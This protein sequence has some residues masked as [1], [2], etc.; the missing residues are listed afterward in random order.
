MIDLLHSFPLHF[1]ILNHMY[2]FY[3]IDAN[4]SQV[5]LILFYFCFLFLLEIFL[6]LFNR[7][8]AIFHNIVSLYSFTQLCSLTHYLLYALYINS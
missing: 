6:F 7:A 2:V 1:R 4:Y 3:V 8:H 5:Q